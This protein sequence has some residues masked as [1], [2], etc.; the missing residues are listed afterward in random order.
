MKKSLL[1]IALACIASAYTQAQTKESILGEAAEQDVFNKKFYWGL[2]WNQ[3]WGKIKGSNLPETYFNKP[4]IGFNLRA[5]YYIL[6]FLGIGAG[7]GYQQRG[8][9][10]ITPDN[11]GGAFTHPWEEP[12]YDA[13]STYRNRL[14]FKTLELPIT[15]LLRVPIVKGLQLSGAAG[16]V[17]MRVNGATD[18]FLSV[19]DGYHK[20]TD[21]TS[22]YL[23]SDMGYQIS[24]GPEIDA[25]TSCVLQVHFVYTSGT[26]NVFA[27]GASNGTQQ[28][29]GFRAACLFWTG[30]KK[31]KN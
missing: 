19:E 29:F 18:Y 7:F 24:I 3:Y 12:M 20:I 11:Y 26:K 28:T 9:G 6:P 4:C 23:K 30:D 31:N 5:E 1:I 2:S 25:G 17:L 16:V 27:N 10:I 21:I 14:R 8:T 15:I 22:D 13:D